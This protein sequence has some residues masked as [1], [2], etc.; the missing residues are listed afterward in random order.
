MV[1][2]EQCA[3]CKYFLQHFVKSRSGRLL[4]VECG[5][6][7]HSRMPFYMPRKRKTPCAYWQPM[8]EQIEERRKNIKEKLLYMAELIEQFAEALADDTQAAAARDD[9]G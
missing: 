8:R 9:N 5:H 2:I 4:K 7:V 1:D 6:C 3:N